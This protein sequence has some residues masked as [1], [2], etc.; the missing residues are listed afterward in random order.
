[1]ISAATERVNNG[2]VSSDFIKLFSRWIVKKDRN[3]FKP[4]IN[5]TILSDLIAST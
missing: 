3:D 4:A 2:F 5:T 1:M